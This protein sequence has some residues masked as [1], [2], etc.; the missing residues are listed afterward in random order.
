MTLYEFCAEPG[1]RTHAAKRDVERQ[2]FSKAKFSV[3]S[4]EK[5]RVFCG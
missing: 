5:I 4:T 3:L 2:V 1:S